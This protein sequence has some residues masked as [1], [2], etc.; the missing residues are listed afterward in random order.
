VG[1]LR[2]GTGDMI[3]D[4]TFALN[5]YFCNVFTD[6]RN[7]PDFERCVG[8]DI[9]MKNVTF[10]S[11]LVFKTL[12]KCKTSRSLDD[13]FC[14]SFVKKLKSTLAY[15]L[16]KKSTLA[17]PLAVLFTHILSAALFPILSVLH[18]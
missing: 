3:T 15:P 17:Y 2:S 5:E 6:D 9:A 13:C 7:T 12:T 18:T 14:M 11:Y 4:D 10:S 8:D 1:P 16:K